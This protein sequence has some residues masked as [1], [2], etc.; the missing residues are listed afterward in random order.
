MKIPKNVDFLKPMILISKRLPSLRVLG[1]VMLCPYNWI[2]FQS[3][4][5]DFKLV[6]HIICQPF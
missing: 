5:L 6:N 1:F 3:Q 4:T 2:F